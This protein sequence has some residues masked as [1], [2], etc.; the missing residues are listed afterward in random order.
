MKI[1]SMK[2]RWLSIT[3]L[4]LLLGSSCTP[5]IVQVPQKS[6]TTQ[7]VTFV[8]NT[9]QPT[10]TLTPTPTESPTPSPTFTPTPELIYPVSYGTPFPT[11]SAVISPVNFDKLR[12]LAVLGQG[13]FNN[14]AWSPDGHY[15]AV[16]SPVGAYLYDAVSMNLILTIPFQDQADAY[17]LPNSPGV[18][19]SS[20]SQYF[21]VACS[22]GIYIYDLPKLNQKL[23]IQPDVRASNLEFLTDNSSI[24]ACLENGTV[25]LYGIGDQKLIESIGSTE[26]NMGKCNLLVS[27]DGNTLAW[28]LYASSTLH[29][30][31]LTDNTP[32]KDFD[33][34]NIIN[35]ALSQDGSTL[36]V[37]LP[38]SEFSEDTKFIDTKTGSIISILPNHII[39]SFSK[40]SDLLATSLDVTKP[41][42]QRCTGQIYIWRLSDHKLIRT[43]VGSEGYSTIAF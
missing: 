3:F 20:D 34:G 33:L 18:I 23:Y 24:A 28:W 10:T 32:G 38:S 35:A 2:T 37:T 27:G 9:P 41:F 11:P 15:L 1:S 16:T 7:S 8:I 14:I 5:S 22:E 25:D 6:D 43:I 26:K 13:F 42:T 21:A 40:S 4:L 29:T 17:G 31:N 39:E 30:W 12:Q 36:A 19:F